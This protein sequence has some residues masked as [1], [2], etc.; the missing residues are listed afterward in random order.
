MAPAVV[1]VGTTTTPIPLPAVDGVVVVNS[2]EGLG[3]IA[4]APDI[5]VSTGPAAALSPQQVGCRLKPGQ[6]QQF[7]LSSPA[8]QLALSAIATAAGAVLTLLLDEGGGSW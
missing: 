1:A 4:G 5:V 2:S 3:D 6:M 7:S 8:G